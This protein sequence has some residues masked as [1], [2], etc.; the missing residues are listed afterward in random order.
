MDA[1][2]LRDFQVLAPSRLDVVLVDDSEA[3]EERRSNNTGTGRDL[4]LA[5]NLC[6]AGIK[7]RK[8]HPKQH[9][10]RPHQVAG[11]NCSQ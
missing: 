11:R 6:Q 2:W 7:Q 9:K 3:E 1:V 8:P 5:Y 10:L 4:S